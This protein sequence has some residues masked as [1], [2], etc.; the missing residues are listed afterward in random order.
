MR[1]IIKV[2][3]VVLFGGGFLYM[4]FYCIRGLIRIIIKKHK[5]PKENTLESE[6]A[7]DEIAA[8]EIDAG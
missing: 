1:D 6:G 3:F 8:D 5:H 4:I 2:L 7:K